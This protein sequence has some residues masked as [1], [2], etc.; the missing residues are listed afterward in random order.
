[1]SWAKRLAGYLRPKRTSNQRCSISSKLGEIERAV[2][3]RWPR[4]LP[5]TSLGSFIARGFALRAQRGIS[6]V[7]AEAFLDC[8]RTSRHG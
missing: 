4:G 1:M 7:P 8:Y 3:H 6:Q 2:S 5:D